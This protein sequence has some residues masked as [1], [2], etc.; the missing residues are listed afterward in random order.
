M[1]LSDSDLQKYIGRNVNEA[2]NELKDQ[3]YKVH[4]VRVGSCATGFVPAQK[5]HLGETQVEKE[6]RAVLTFDG[7]D[8][9]HKVVSI[10]Q[11]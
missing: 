11:D 2:E 7:D 4:R 1:S 6:K 9:N 8:S 3:G 5:L 10:R